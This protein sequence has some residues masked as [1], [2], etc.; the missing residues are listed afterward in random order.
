ML[1]IVS[2]LPLFYL[3]SNLDFWRRGRD[4]NPRSSFPDNNLAGCSIRPLWHLSVCELRSP[5]YSEQSVRTSSS[6]ERLS[7]RAKQ[8]RLPS[9]L[10]KT[11]S[12]LC[13]I[14]SGTSPYI[15]R[16]TRLYL[17]SGFFSSYEW[18]S[19]A[20]STEWAPAARSARRA[21]ASEAPVVETSSTTT[22]TLPAILF[23]ASSESTTRIEFF[24]FVS[25]WCFCNPCCGGVALSRIKTFGA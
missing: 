25:R 4:S 21:S 18:A 10:D 2:K 7:R 8:R 22:H 9:A 24:T 14:P 1:L 16:A 5:Q 3:G 15:V 12:S 23:R 6:S 19:A 13:F 20:H 17:F 11:Q